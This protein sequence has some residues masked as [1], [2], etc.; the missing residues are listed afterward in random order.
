MTVYVRSAAVFV[1]RDKAVT[2]VTGAETALDTAGFRH[3]TP[4]AA[5]Q[6]HLPEVGI[7]PARLQTEPDTQ[8]RL[9]IRVSID[10]YSESLLLLCFNDLTSHVS[11][12]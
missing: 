6:S 2:L 10:F 3:D 8:N 12:P 1:G 4:T 11:C 5:S 7:G 9:Y